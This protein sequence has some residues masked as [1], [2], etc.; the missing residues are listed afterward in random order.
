MA[1]SKL[2]TEEMKRLA[3]A[4]I[5]LSMIAKLAEITLQ[6]VRYR[7]N[8]NYQWKPDEYEYTPDRKYLKTQRE[9]QQEYQQI[10]LTLAR[11][12]GAWTDK[13]V[14]FLEKNAT[15]LTV[16]ELALELQRTYYSV[17]HFVSRHGIKTRK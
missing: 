9:R 11:T 3:R 10:S 15:D 17:N 13:E 7:I 16:L 6:G 1:K 5:K 8:P 12:F 4:G 14:R 2:S